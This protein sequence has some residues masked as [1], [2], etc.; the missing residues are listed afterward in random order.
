MTNYYHCRTI[1]SSTT[2]PIGRWCLSLNCTAI[3]AMLSCCKM[4][5]HTAWVFPTFYHSS[6]SNSYS[7]QCGKHMNCIICVIIWQASDCP[8]DRVRY[9]W[10]DEEMDVPK[11]IIWRNRSI[12]CVRQIDRQL[13]GSV[14][15]LKLRN[16]WTQQL[17][18]K[19]QIFC[20]DQWNQRNIN[21]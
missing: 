15:V 6:P 5:S 2:G 18:S 19:S 14:L 12:S 20:T 13:K 16:F 21:N 3:Y 11:R 8:V 4:Y 9:G 1:S 10:R 17:T 7:W